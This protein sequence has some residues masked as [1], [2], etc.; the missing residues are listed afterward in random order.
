[1]HAV[2]QVLEWLDGKRRDASAKLMAAVKPRRRLFWL[3]E[4]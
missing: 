2:R 4:R 1:M 3:Q